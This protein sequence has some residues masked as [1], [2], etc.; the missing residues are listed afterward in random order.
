VT[1][2]QDTLFDEI[3]WRWTRSNGVVS[4]AFKPAKPQPANADWRDAVTRSGGFGFV[5]DRL[6]DAGRHQGNLLMLTAASLDIVNPRDSSFF[7][8]QRLPAVPADRLDT[9]RLPGGEV[10]LYRVHGGSTTRWN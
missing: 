4:V 2:F 7:T 3:T 1:L 10:R 8:V 6:I 5:F 9:F